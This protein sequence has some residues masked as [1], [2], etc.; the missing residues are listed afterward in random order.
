MIHR[1]FNTFSSVEEFKK[2]IL[3]KYSFK[4]FL[5]NQE[6][7]KV[8]IILKQ[9]S[10]AFLDTNRIISQFNTEPT[11]DVIELNLIKIFYEFNKIGIFKKD[12]TILETEEYKNDE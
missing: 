4:Q 6:F 3:L 1:R 7:Q 11:N 10:F 9:N 12:F 8:K 5:S 2:Q